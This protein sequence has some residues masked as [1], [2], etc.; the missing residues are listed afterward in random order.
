[1]H[2]LTISM[3]LQITRKRI[4]SL[5]CILLFFFV[6]KPALPQDKT[7]YMFD[8]IL[9]HHY[10][11]VILE[12]APL[13]KGNISTITGNYRLNSRLQSS[14]SAGFIYQ[15]NLDYKWNIR[16]GL[17]LNVM[18]TNYYMHIP[19]TDLRG[20]PSTSGAPQIEDKQVYFKLS[21][22]ILLTY[23]FSFSKCGFYS[24][25]AGGKINYSGLS[26][27]ET[28]NVQMVDYSG[29]FTTL[30]SGDFASNN[31]NKPWISYVGNASK[32]F[33][34]RNG[35]LFSI[36]LF[37]ELS[38]TKFIRGNYQILVPNKPVSDGTYSVNGSCIGISLQYLFPKPRKNFFH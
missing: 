30:F 8:S 13:P 10:F 9:P 12:A 37:G 17:E 23:N 22:P 11:G 16:Y 7:L 31:N 18:N 33:L 38:F 27:D 1:M 20:Y 5:S 15:V 34:L 35:G 19:D 24:I 14:F 32:T 2:C 6:M 36:D 3:N 29:Q 21:L 25:H 28:T 4:Y 26:S